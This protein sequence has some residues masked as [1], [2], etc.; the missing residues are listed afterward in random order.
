MMHIYVLGAVSV[1]AFVAHAV[2]PNSCY[3]DFLYNEK[4]GIFDK[5]W[6]TNSQPTVTEKLP[7]EN[8]FEILDLTPQILR[9][10]DNYA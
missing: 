2:F 7:K 4:K 10:L 8:V 1:S 5:F 3:H 6:L 9:D